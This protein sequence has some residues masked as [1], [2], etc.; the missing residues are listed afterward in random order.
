MAREDDFPEP[1]RRAVALRAGYHCSFEGCDQLTVGPS[2]ES[3]VAVSGVGIA[4][5][6]SAASPGGRRHDPA[7]SSEA[8]RHIGNAIWL[9]ANHAT[10]IDRDEMSYTTERL[11]RMKVAHEEG[12]R[13]QLA[14]PRSEAA[15][16]DDLIAVGPSVVFLGQ[17]VG[18]DDSHWEVRVSHFVAG[19]VGSLVEYCGRFNSCV[20]ADQYV[21]VNELGDGRVLTQAPNWRRTEGRVVVRCEIAP[22]FARMRAQD[23]GEDLRIAP[24]HDFA[25]ENDDLATVSGVEAIPQRIMICL[26]TQKNELVGEGEFGTRLR[27]YFQLYAGTEWFERLIKLEAVRLSS[28]PHFDDMLNEEYTPML[29]VDRVRSI[30]VKSVPTPGQWF[31]IALVLDVHGLGAWSHELAIYLPSDHVK[32]S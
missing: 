27:A 15:G 13:R 5:H 12:I 1:V 6:I 16:T 7:M 10:L 30:S 22:R 23:L 18:G 31:K 25:E 2:D 8:Q 28:I 24:N 17:L 21:I 4:A 11:V 26:S 20:S 9:C 29:C 14:R 19:D 3:D 32:G